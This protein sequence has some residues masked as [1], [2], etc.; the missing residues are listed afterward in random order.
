MKIL[1]GAHNGGRGLYVEMRSPVVC[2]CR[3]GQRRYEGRCAGGGQILGR[4]AVKR[5][6]GHTPGVCVLSSMG[7]L[8]VKKCEPLYNRVWR[9]KVFARVFDVSFWA[10]VG[11]LGLSWGS[12]KLKKS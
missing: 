1:D 8:H 2:A 4:W 3:L 6:A 9:L 10:G 11:S 7:L 12:K 5:L